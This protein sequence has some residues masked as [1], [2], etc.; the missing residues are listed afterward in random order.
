[1]GSVGRLKAV[2]I[3]SM[4]TPPKQPNV[5]IGLGVAFLLLGL[6]ALPILL[7][8][9]TGATGRGIPMMFAVP[10]LGIGGVGFIIY[11]AYWRSRNRRDSSV[12]DRER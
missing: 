11:G 10:A 5:L 4:A 3:C 7:G 2:S 12:H 1:M 9:P 6:I 8:D